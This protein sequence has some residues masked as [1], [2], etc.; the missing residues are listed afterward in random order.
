MGNKIVQNSPLDIR[1]NVFLVGMMGSGKSYWAQQIS[2]ATNRNWMDLDVEIE[3]ENSMTIKE[4]FDAEGETTF[5]KMEQK[6]LHNLAKYNNII[7]ATG[8]GTPCFFNNMAWM[9][10]SGITIFINET[11]SMLAQRLQSQK[12]HRP[13]IS[14]SSNGNL[15]V[16]LHQR[17]SERIGFYSQAKYTITGSLATVTDFLKIIDSTL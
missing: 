14:S 13:L 11:V 1:G 9:N 16:L 17:L 7:I 12:S 4:I 2:A 15:E 6:A 3:K 5:R 8:G 10:V